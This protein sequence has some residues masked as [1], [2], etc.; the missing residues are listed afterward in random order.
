MQLDEK[1]EINQELT[2]PRQSHGVSSEPSPDN[3]HMLDAQDPIPDTHND[4]FQTPTAQGPFT[5]FITHT[6]SW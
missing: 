4:L 5:K 3:P 2:T 1:N 6:G